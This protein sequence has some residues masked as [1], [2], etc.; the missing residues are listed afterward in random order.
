[1]W[2]SKTTT[3][4]NNSCLIYKGPFFTIEWFYDEDG[5][6]QPYEYFLKSSAGQKR[7]FLL[8]V[9]KMGDFG[10]IIDKKKFRN[11]ENKI[12]A[13]KPKPDRYLCFFRSGKKIIVTNAFRK[14]GDKLPAQEK[15]V[16]LKNMEKYNLVHKNQKEK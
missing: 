4:D 8:L 2:Y 5:Y 1:M 13:F 10:K 11:E 6:S 16:A 7:K 9:K 14:K 15:A 3:I 12:Y